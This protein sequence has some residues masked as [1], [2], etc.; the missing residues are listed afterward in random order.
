[1]IMNNQE[2]GQEKLPSFQ[3]FGAVNSNAL[4]SV[5]V[6]THKTHTLIGMIMNNQ[7][8]GQEKLPSFQH[9]GAVNSNALESVVVFTHKTHTLI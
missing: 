2:G 9:F 6:F 4:E 7:E 1:M 5:V 3:H 8:G